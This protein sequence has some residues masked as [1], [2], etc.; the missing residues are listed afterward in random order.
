MQEFFYEDILKTPHSNMVESDNWKIYYMYGGIPDNRHMVAAV[1]GIV[2]TWLEI[3]EPTMV[4]KQL[5]IRSFF[6]KDLVDRK[7]VACIPAR[8]FSGW[9]ILFEGGIKVPVNSEI[10]YSKATATFDELGFFQCQDYQTF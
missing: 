10:L 5:M 8:E 4:G 1:D 3:E 6:M 2:N 9:N 7:V